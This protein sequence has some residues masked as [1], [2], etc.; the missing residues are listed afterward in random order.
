[1]TWLPSARPA[2]TRRVF[3][4]ALAIALVA[5]LS[6]CM[7]L[8]FAFTVN[9]DDTVAITTLM[10]Y[11]DSVLEEAAAD[12]GLTVEE[13]LA[14]SGVEEQ[15]Q[16]LDGQGTV[17]DYHEDGYT[18]WVIT[19]SELAPLGGVTIPGQLG[20]AGALN[21]ERQGDEFVLSGVIDVERM[22]GDLSAWGFDE[23]EMQEALK[24]VDFE[25]VFTFP[26]PVESATGVIDANT[27]TFSP[28]WGEPL[29]VNAV[30]SAIP[31]APPVEDPDDSGSRAVLWL[32][33]AGAVIVV[34][35]AILV[36]VRMSRRKKA[37]HDADQDGLGRP[38]GGF[39]PLP[40]APGSGSQ[41]ARPA[42]AEAGGAEGAERAAGAEAAEE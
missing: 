22:P 8:R 24:T 38:A 32:A 25:F 13:F 19:G 34:A 18:G 27:V 17:E 1:M 40:A 10:A 3:A 35:G 37:A 28:K 41:A 36:A 5:A 29:E 14:Q 30:A 11:E 9:P 4:A 12:Q 15:F 20:Q 23:P 33:L 31:P 16:K 42:A 6:G 2:A 7:K 26:G 21:L 39:G